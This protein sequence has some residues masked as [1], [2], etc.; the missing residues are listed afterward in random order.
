[1]SAATVRVVFCQLGALS[2]SRMDKFYWNPSRHVRRT[3]FAAS[4]TCRRRRFCRLAA[5]S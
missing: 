3:I 2:R 4:R 5:S 1:M